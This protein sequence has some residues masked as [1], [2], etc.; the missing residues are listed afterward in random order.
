MGHFCSKNTLLQLKHYIQRL[1]LTLLSTTCLKIHQILYVIFETITDLSRHN[2]F[3]FIQLSITQQPI[4]VLI[5]RL[6]TAH[7]KI[8]QIPHAI[9]LTKSKFSF[10]VWITLQCHERYSSV[11]FQ[12]KLYM[13]LTKVVHQSANFQTFDCSHENEPNYQARSQI[14]FK[15]YITLQCNDT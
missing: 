6:Y 4:R 12:Q 15:F 11:P 8:H 9:S 14:S 7:V 2:S 5:F 1:Y 3:V 10:K 13:L